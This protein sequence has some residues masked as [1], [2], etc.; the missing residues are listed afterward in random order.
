MESSNKIVLEQPGEY[1]II[2]RDGKAPDV[3][4]YS[5]Q[6]I[7]QSG[8]I[9]AP[10]SFYLVRKGML[11]PDNTE[12]FQKAFTHVL[13]NREAGTLELG[14]GRNHEEQQRI[15]GVVQYAEQY[16]DLKLNNNKETV[17]PKELAGILKRYRYLFSEQQEAMKV[18]ADLQAFKA[19]IKTNIVAELDGR[20]NKKN[21]V[22]TSIESNVPIKFGMKIELFKGFKKQK[23]EVNICFEQ[24][25]AN[26]VE[27]WLESLDA[28]EWFDKQREDLFDLELAP[29]IQDDIAIIES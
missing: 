8:I 4:V 27:C 20:G 21:L 18:I 19:D 7:K 12:F 17:S 22:E 23:I 13:V 11:L 16:K 15:S 3:K 1:T 24:A 14:W 28:L 25:G 5:P 9:S 10:R 2:H 29:F 26:S 6:Q